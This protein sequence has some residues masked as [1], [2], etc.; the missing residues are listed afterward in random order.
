MSPSWSL[1]LNR[2]LLVQLDFFPCNWKSFDR[3]ISESFSD[4]FIL[5]KIGQNLVSSFRAGC[6]IQLRTD[7]AVELSKMLCG[8]SSAESPKETP[9]Q[10]SLAA[11]PDISGI[12][13]LLEEFHLW[14]CV[15]FCP[16]AHL[17]Q[18]C[19]G[20]S[21]RKRRTSSGRGQ[22]VPWHLTHHP[23]N[24]FSPPLVGHHV[25]HHIHFWPI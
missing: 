22:S 18:N 8:W 4:R 3:L 23:C 12:T 16:R 11:K 20:M 17:G 6:L 2:Y 25:L 14:F 7:P 24:S 1:M 15:I 5:N 19:I 9:I 10:A 21:A 13:F